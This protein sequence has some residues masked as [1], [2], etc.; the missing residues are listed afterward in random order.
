VEVA[1]A[2]HPAAAG[3]ERAGIATPA[4]RE[5]QGV[6]GRAVHLDVEDAPEMI[7]AVADRAVDLRD[8]RS[9]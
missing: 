4:L 8:A 2:D 3:R 6:V 7:E 5:H 1:A 9:E